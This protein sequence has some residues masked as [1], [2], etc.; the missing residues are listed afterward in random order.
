MDS[1]GCSKRKMI[2]T[3]NT[4]WTAGQAINLTEVVQIAHG[5]TLTVEPGAIINGNGYGIEA[6]GRLVANGTSTQ[7]ITF[8]DVDV[9]FGNSSSAAPGYIAISHAQM[10]G[11][12]FLYANSKYG[13]FT[14]TD[15]IISGLNGYIYAWYPTA[16]SFIERNIFHNSGGISA[17]VI[18][19]N[20]IFIRNNVFVEQTTPFA[21]EN[22]A[23]YGTRTVVEFNSFLS[24]DRVALALGSGY[25]NAA[26]EAGS[27][28]FNTSDPTM[29]N[30]MV[31]DR[32]D[33]LNYASYINV[34]NPLSSPHQSTPV[35]DGPR[36]V[37]GIKAQVIAEDT[38]WSFQIPAAVFSDVDG[39]FTYK[40]TYDG[41]SLPD[42]LT[43][44]ASTRTLSGTPP[45]DWNGFLTFKVTAAEG[46][47]ATST[48]FNLDVMPVNDAP[49]LAQAIQ[50]R[51]VSQNQMARF[52][53]PWDTFTDP[54]YD[55][56][57]FTAKLA[58]GS[59]L[60]GWLSFDAV[61]KTFSGT[62][63]A[64]FEGALDIVVTASDGTLSTSDT[65][66]LTVGPS[67][68][69]PENQPPTEVVLTN[70]TIK[71]NSAAGTVVGWFSAFDPDAGD[72]FT[73][74]LTDNAGGR[75][76]LTGDGKGLAVANG[77]LLD[78]ELGTSYTIG[79]VATDSGGLSVSR[80]IAVSVENVID[81]VIVG[82]AGKD[83][84][85]GGSGAD[86]LIGGRGQ[87]T[88]TGGGGKDVFVFGKG[89]TTASRKTADYITD[90][91]G[92]RGD[93]IDISAID[94]DVRKSGNQKFA[95]IGTSEFSKPG[96]VRYEKTKKETYVLL[97]TDNDKAAEGV[98]KLKG[99]MDLHKNWFFL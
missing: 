97:N 60:P 45:R 85:V 11:G 91:S 25:D 52:S 49:V 47:F 32:N 76:A 88:L 41:Q 57:T 17:G 94:A 26:I 36:L 37:S 80:T 23:A 79:V 56:L 4:I 7:G 46:P 75:F 42:W 72:A 63:P 78:Y 8:N 44:D 69:P 29:I 61:Y 10:N 98:I 33:S 28:F 3:T 70:A 74:T 96:Q 84:I 55:D 20:D 50:D 43:F 83:G 59:A 54:D 12:S 99:G 95:F 27:N 53:I 31:R 40:V 9:G 93:R 30:A 14:L 58:G 24:T 77:F 81:E 82:T 73:Y 51:A 68:R 89:H 6:L 18:F 19:G 13:A 48:F 62:P 38:G 35:Y 2:I 86:R 16:D 39:S 66:R 5:A 65:F 92:K 34:D 90:F 87:D 21:V 1:V 71:E 64:N 15:N 22:W 67:S